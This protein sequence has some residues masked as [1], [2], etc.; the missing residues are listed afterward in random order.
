M[1]LPICASQDRPPARPQQRDRRHDPLA[2]LVGGRVRNQQDVGAG[3]LRL[4][5][6]K[7]P[8]VHPACQRRNVDLLR[9]HRQ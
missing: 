2:I 9:T 6:R 1:S 4:G 5:G 7:I 3:D 8:T